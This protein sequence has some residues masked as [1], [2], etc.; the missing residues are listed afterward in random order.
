MY[1]NTARGIVDM[2]RGSTMSHIFVFERDV[3]C[4]STHYTAAACVISWL[5]V[6]DRCLVVFLIRTVRIAIL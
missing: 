2:L 4:L 6:S 1:V 3:H 5:Q